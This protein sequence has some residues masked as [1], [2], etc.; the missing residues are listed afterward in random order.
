[1]RFIVHVQI[2]KGFSTYPSGTRNRSTS[3]FLELTLVNPQCVL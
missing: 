3:D 2:L 1:M